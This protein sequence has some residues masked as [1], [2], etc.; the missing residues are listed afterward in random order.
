MLL[1]TR[2]PLCARPG[3]A[4]CLTC[5]RQLPPARAG[6]Y[7]AVLAYA[8][9]GRRLV[10]ALKFRNG[11]T[12]AKALGGA[13]ARLIGPGEVDVVTWAPT[14]TRR[15][16]A[17]GYDQAEVLARATARPLGVP[18]RAL[19]RRAD[20][21]GSQTGRGR[22]ERLAL[23]P[24]FVATRPVRGRVL[25]VD[26]VVTT[27]A[28]LHAASMVLLAAGATAVRAVAAAATP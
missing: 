10:H 14:T 8:G 17:R 5:A 16:R 20:Q 2:C 24:S 15:R 19:L 1:P 27:G 11:R 7:P 9:D 6:P 28:T 18:V 3:P 25:V 22:R 21:A 23:A 13:M 26:D 4:P 12:V